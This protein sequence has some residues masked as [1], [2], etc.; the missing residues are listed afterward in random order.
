MNEVEAVKTRNEIAA[1]EALLRKHHGELYADI[2]K[3]GLNLSLR[4][5][6][7]LAI[8]FNDLD[9]DR[10]EFVLL[11][12]KTGKKRTIRLNDTALKIIKRRQKEYPT[13]AFL[14][15]VHSNRA[16]GKPISRNSVSRAFKDAG[17]RIG[18]RI[19]TH[20]MRKSRGYVMFSD[21]VPIEKVSKVL[22]HSHPAVTMR[23]LGITN[24]EVL[25]SYDEY[26]L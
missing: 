25:D 16:E 15:Q 21:G 4:I 26:E 22:N 2:W 24:K 6:D 1:I 10:R 14:F 5:S 13:D 11:E 8:K 9:L 17:D 23:Y 3:I 20:S 12:G 7:L 18:L 19:N